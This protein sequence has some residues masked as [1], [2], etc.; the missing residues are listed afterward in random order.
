MVKTTM[1]K[2]NIMLVIMK[3]CFLLRDNLNKNFF[4]DFNTV[5]ATNKYKPEFKYF[6]DSPT[7]TAAIN[8]ND[9]AELTKL[10]NSFIKE[11]LS[12]IENF[13]PIFESI[14]QPK[15]KSSLK[16]SI[17]TM[18]DRVTSVCSLNSNVD[19]WNARQL[20]MIQLAV[21]SVVSLES[22]K[23]ITT[24]LL[25]FWNKKID[26][27]QL[28]KNEL[29]LWLHNLTRCI[30]STTS[31]VYKI[32]ATDIQSK[33]PVCQLLLLEASIHHNSLPFMQFGISIV[34]LDLNDDVKAP[35]DTKMT[36]KNNQWQHWTKQFV[37][38]LRGIDSARSDDNKTLKCF[39]E[40]GKPGIPMKEITYTMDG[41]IKKVIASSKKR[42]EHCISSELLIQPPEL[43]KLQPKESP[44]VVAAP[45]T[46]PA[47]MSMDTHKFLRNNLESLM[48]KM[49]EYK[50]HNCLKKIW[51]L[52]LQDINK[53]KAEFPTM[54]ASYVKC[55]EKFAETEFP[56]SNGLKYVK[57]M[58]GFSALLI[59]D[60]LQ[61]T[62]SND[63]MLDYKNALA[64]VLK[65]CIAGSYS[66]GEFSWHMFF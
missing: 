42:K 49:D 28:D 40:W 60:Y 50:I 35:T 2:D 3:F 51:K 66:K 34:S 54:K 14:K 11:T 23:S 37:E 16:N 58:T 25:N 19:N 64:H 47:K 38:Y 41:F 22:F 55:C 6:M 4:M 48:E 18:N 62:A 13:G 61:T 30:L 26:V 8:N 27:K 1:D 21:W 12:Q 17:F 53:C 10:I 29:W 45:L 5:T 20:I 52:K 46:L 33:N 7:V 9:P 31:C 32:N 36:S 43:I 65:H 57:I 44:V 39:G 63:M 24:I 56:S 59:Y 15:I